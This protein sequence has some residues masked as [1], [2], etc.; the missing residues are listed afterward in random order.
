MYRVMLP[1]LLGLWLIGGFITVGAEEAKEKYLFGVEH[2]KQST[3]RIQGEQVIYFDPYKVEQELHDADLVF[4]SHSHGDHLSIPDL[5][6]VAK[7][8][9]VLVAPV[10]SLAKLQ[11][12]GFTKITTVVPNQNY[13]VLG[14][15]F[16]TVPAY[17]IG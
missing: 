9:T 10:E 8:S 4:I 14:I 17:N 1:I 7:E 2:F 13:E 6:K 5:K 16:A 11:Q 15:K 12:G 3:V